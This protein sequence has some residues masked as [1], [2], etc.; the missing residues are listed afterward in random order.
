MP[1]PSPST[2]L[3]LQ[4]IAPETLGII[5]PALDGAG[6]S[7]TYVR[8]FLGEPVP[9]DPG[10]AA[11]LI[12]MGGPMGVYEQDRHP[13]L[14]DELRLIESAIAAGKPVLGVCLGSQLVAHALG[15]NVRPSGRKEIG[16][17]ELT[18][19]PAAGSDPL[20]AG[21]PSRTNVFHW[22]GDIFDLPSGATRLAA[23]AMTETQ[24][25]RHGLNV[26]GLLCHMEVTETIVRGM[27]A[28]F[29]DELAAEGLSGSAIVEESRTR[30]PGLQ[31]VGGTVFERW[32]ALAVPR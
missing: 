8:P 6:L 29:T 3:V 24:V 22:H 30:L 9:A 19:A 28:A 12:V 13:H 16:W 26:Y 5:E 21:L 11:G 17:H 18:L 23:S 15:A 7:H 31:P 1:R 32:A 27:S 4:H 20:F 2:V 14:T 10:D 25:F